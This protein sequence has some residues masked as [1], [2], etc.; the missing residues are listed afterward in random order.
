MT[1]YFINATHEK[2]IRS[3]IRQFRARSIKDG[4]AAGISSRHG[5]RGEQL[6]RRRYVRPQRLGK[7]V[8]SITQM[9]A[10][11][12]VKRKGITKTQIKDFVPL[13]NWIDRFR[14]L[15]YLPGQYV[16]GGQQGGG[17]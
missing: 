3:M 6:Y 9:G 12:I 8:G 2:K 17:A 11:R 4:K 5:S 7:A 15:G 16:P 10:I 13:A 1:F 14:R